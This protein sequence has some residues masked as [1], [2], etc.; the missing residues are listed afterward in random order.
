MSLKSL[1]REPLL[2]FLAIGATLFL[3]FQS[4]EDYTHKE[5][6]KK[7]ILRMGEACFFNLGV[8]YSF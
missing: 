7:A 6:G 8:A 2:H 3:Q 1:L 4:V 5:G